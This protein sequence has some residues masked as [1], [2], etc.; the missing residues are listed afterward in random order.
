MVHRQFVRMCNRFTVYDH[1]TCGEWLRTDLVQGI[2]WHMNINSYS[3]PQEI[4]EAVRYKTRRNWPIMWEQQKP[5]TTVSLL[6]YLH[7][8]KTSMEVRVNGV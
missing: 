2:R 7:E 6:K 5:V 3:T 8:Q 4:H 1:G